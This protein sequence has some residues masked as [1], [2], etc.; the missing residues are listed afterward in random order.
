ME[1]IEQIPSLGFRHASKL[2]SFSAQTSRAISCRAMPF[3]TTRL[4]Q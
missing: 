3:R 4:I 2:G 1:Q